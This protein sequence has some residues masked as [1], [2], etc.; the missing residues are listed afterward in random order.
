MAHAKHIAI[1]GGGPAGLKAAETAAE[2]GAIVSL[3]DAKRSVGRKFLIAGKSGLNLTSDESFATF[4][5]KYSGSQQPDGVW[6]DLLSDFDNTATR[7]WAASLGIETFV[8]S[9]KKV[10][11]EQM[12]AAP[13]LR[14]WVTKLK[15]IGV[16]FHVNH[17]LTKLE[18]ADAPAL[19]FDTPDGAVTHSFDHVILA[20]GGGSW[21]STGSDGSWVDSLRA[22][23]IT[24]HSLSAANS[25]WE[26]D[27]PPALLTA[28][29]GL[30]IKNIVIHSGEKSHHGEVVITRYGLEG[31]PIYRLGP[32][33]RQCKEIEIDFKPTFSEAQLVAKMESAKRKLLTEAI[34]RWKLSPATAAILEH[35]HQAAK[36][37]TT[38]LA[39]L[40]KHCTITCH[41][42]RPIDEAI[43]SAG[44]ICWTELDSQLRLIKHPSLSACGEMIDWEAPT[45]GFL[46]QGCLA[47]G[48]RAAIGALSEC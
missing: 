39:H 10:F 44:G 43:S 34:R 5:D 13:L 42:P 22:L 14:R 3:F 30:P 20:L 19:H 15:E 40:V 35:Y 2:L 41:R 38:Q 8:S 11:P 45:G 48:K 47:T 32:Q 23:D 36:L 37:N 16:S 6:Q 7:E 33:I 24:V 46:L 28:A 9:A 29:E 25:G 4:V 1:I 31:G 26:T 12:K 18:L 27:W 21:K 17:R